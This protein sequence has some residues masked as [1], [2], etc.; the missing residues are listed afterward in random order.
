MSVVDFYLIIIPLCSVDT[1]GRTCWVTTSRLRVS[2]IPYD[3]EVSITQRR[4]A[5]ARSKRRSAT[6]PEDTDWTSSAGDD[7]RPPD[8]SDA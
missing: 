2:I 1:N 5:G 6:S 3:P 4:S 7:R 8:G